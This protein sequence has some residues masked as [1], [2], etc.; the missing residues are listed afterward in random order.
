MIDLG[1][2]D[3]LVNRLSDSLPPAANRLKEDAEKQFR[4][5]LKSAF[6]KM[7][8]VSREEFDIQR[9]VLERTQLKLEML[10]LQLQ[11]LEKKGT[12]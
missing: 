7:D 1:K 11:E 6:E 12:G 3:D 2:I 8:L 4:S 9:S 10:E 5:V